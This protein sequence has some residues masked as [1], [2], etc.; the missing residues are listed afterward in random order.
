MRIRQKA[1]IADILCDAQ[2]G[3]RDVAKLDRLA[4]LFRNLGLYRG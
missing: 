4:T 3:K 1:Q 2:Q